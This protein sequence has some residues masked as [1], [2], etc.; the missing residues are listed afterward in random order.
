VRETSGQAVVDIAAAA[1]PSG[2]AGSTAR[3]T[4]RPG[5]DARR[6]RRLL[7][8]GDSADER[9]GYGGLGQAGLVRVVHRLA[10]ASYLTV[11]VAAGF[12]TPC[13]SLRASRPGG[14]PLPTEH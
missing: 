8:H 7:G 14:R 4:R 10:A 12:R 2:T 6:R 11:W 3:L 13:R 5:S 9:D 1:R